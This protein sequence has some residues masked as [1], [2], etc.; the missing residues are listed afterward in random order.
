M[1][2]LCCIRSY[3]K[4]KSEYDPIQWGGSDST[5]SVLCNSLSLN[6]SLLLSSFERPR[7]SRFSGLFA[8]LLKWRPARGIGMEHS[9]FRSHG[10]NC[11]AI[12]F[13]HI[14]FCPEGKG[15]PSFEWLKIKEGKTSGNSKKIQEFPNPFC[16]VSQ[17]RMHDICML[18]D[19][20]MILEWAFFLCEFDGCKT[21]KIRVGAHLGPTL[22]ILMGNLP[23][24]FDISCMK[25]V[26]TGF[27]VNF[28]GA[29][30]WIFL[31]FA[32]R[33]IKLYSEKISSL[34]PWHMSTTSGNWT[35]TGSDRFA[36]SLS[37]GSTC[38]N[39]L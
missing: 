18:L 1:H 34:R 35:M 22:E 31:F 28:G 15:M 25:E 19:A 30:F 11:F 20:R 7:S 21:A 27:W 12:W 16:L 36:K 24:N 6:Q 23:R 26:T 38:T 37:G 8:W 32:I 10:T 14:P 4:S 17:K 29:K 2:V 33:Y 3:K 13:C 39:S 9:L 5:L